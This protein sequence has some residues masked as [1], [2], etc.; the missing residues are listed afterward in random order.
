MS[1]LN[2]FSRRNHKK[3]AVFI[4]IFWLGF[5]LLFWGFIC[6]WRVSL[7]WSVGYNSFQNKLLV[8]FVNFKE[9]FQRRKKRKKEKRIKYFPLKKMTHILKSLSKNCFTESAQGECQNS[10]PRRT[11]S[12]YFSR[13]NQSKKFWTFWQVSWEWSLLRMK[14]TI[15]LCSFKNNI[16]EGRVFKTRLKPFKTTK[17]YKKNL[18]L[19]IKKILYISNI[20]NILNALNWIFAAPQ[21]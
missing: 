18:K 7:T 12:R 4:V 16:F 2:K 9:K 1:F 8:E 20:L 14:F 21:K 11:N 13:I 6:L 15:H 10:W 5:S 19:L 3:I 17:L